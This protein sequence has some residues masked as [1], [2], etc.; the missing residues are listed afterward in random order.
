VTI[1]EQGEMSHFPTCVP[2][3]KTKT[4]DK[5]EETK[6][7]KRKNAGK[8]KTHFKFENAMRRPARNKKKQ[9]QDTTRTNRI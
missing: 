3:E 4:E 8:E 1:Y 9:R 5:K 7:K 2:E 6:K